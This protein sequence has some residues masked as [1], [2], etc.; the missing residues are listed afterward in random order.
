MKKPVAVLIVSLA[1]GFALLGEG[2]TLL[3][4]NSVHSE[5]ATSARVRGAWTV[6]K[7]R[8]DPNLKVAALLDDDPAYMGAIVTFA[9]DAITWNSAK[10]NGK[11][12]YD[13]CKHPSYAMSADNPGFYA[14][15]CDGDTSGFEMTVKPVNADTL[16][17]N[18]YDGGIL[19][20]TRNP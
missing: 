14:V 12:T 7:V 8:T 6:T 3:A 13:A 17:V 16:I 4:A 19:T 1:I 15:K 11:G 2:T 5:L 9:G 10:T 20:L 18:W